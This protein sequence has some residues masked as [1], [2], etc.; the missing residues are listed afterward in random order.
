MSLSITGQVV[1]KDSVK[2]REKAI[3]DRVVYKKEMS[4]SEI[5]QLGDVSFNTVETVPVYPGCTSEENRVL[6]NCFNQKVGEHIANSFDF[7]LP[8]TLGL[9]PGKKRMLLMF[10]INKNGL[11]DNI[12]VK[13]PHPKLKEEGERVLKLLP[14]FTPGKIQ[15]ESVPVTF[16]LPLRFD[17]TN[18][19]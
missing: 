4:K 6:K 10:R 2:T 11:V 8:N 7:K 14:K 16:T 19:N 3:P 12:I 18:T 15:G 17:V 13:A 9:S 1:K 5:E